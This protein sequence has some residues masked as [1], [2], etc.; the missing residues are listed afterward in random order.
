MKI[1]DIYTYR[2]I[3]SRLDA[4]LSSAREFDCSIDDY[5][6]QVLAGDSKAEG[7]KANGKESRR[8]AAEAREAGKALRKRLRE[9]EAEATRLTGQRDAIDAALS[10]DRKSV[11]T[12][13]SVSLRV[14]LG[15]ARILKQKI[16]L[17]I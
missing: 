7:K 1:T 2:Q 10:E 4:L 3:R 6:A 15:V 13:K 16:V 8:A 14:D 17:T 9:L 11:G 12:G 5:I